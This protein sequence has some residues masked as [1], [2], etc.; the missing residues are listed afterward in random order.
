M[1]VSQ[2]VKVLLYFYLH[3]QVELKAVHHVTYHSVP[4]HRLDAA[5][6]PEKLSPE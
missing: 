5:Q 6:R 4:N 2:D 1:S 3:T